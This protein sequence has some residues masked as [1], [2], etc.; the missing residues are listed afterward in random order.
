M[1]IASM[2]GVVK[3][4]GSQLVMD[5][6]DMDIREGEI[7]G[8]LGPNGAGKTTLIQTL[9]GMIPHERGKISLFDSSDKP[10][11]NRNK[12]KIGLVTQEITVFDELTAKDNLKFFASVYGIRGSEKKARVD[13]ALKFV[14]LTDSADMSPSKFSGGMQRRLN[15]ACALT[16]RP[17]FLIMDEPTVGI[18]P[19]SRR[20]IL[21]AVRQLNADGTTILYTTHYMEEIQ[22][23]ASRVVIM[24]Q[25]QIIKEGTVDELVQTLQ[26][27]ERVHIDVTDPDSVPMER[28]ENIEGVK[29]VNLKGSRLT[30]ISEYDSGNLDRIITVVK[31][32]G[33]VLGIQSDKPD[34][35]DVFLT[36]TGRQLRDGG[37]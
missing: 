32:N 15:I 37:E 17:R 35:E 23:I 18:D 34:L 9:T 13:E 3:R 27:E 33:G 20:Y 24:D 28:L 2:D 26:H 29:K 19:Q 7:I 5:Y 21:D 36:L 14:G 30:V 22:D 11:S 12:E 10:F 4:Y 25:G 16:H 31:E 1:A 8:L 6:V